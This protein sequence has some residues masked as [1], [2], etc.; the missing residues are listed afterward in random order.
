VK[1][2]PTTSTKEIEMTTQFKVDELVHPA[3]EFASLFPVAL[4]N[5]TLRVEKTPVGANGVNYTLMPVGGGRGIKAPG[6]MLEAGAAAGPK[7]YA[8]LVTEIESTPILFPGTVVKVKG[9]GDALYVITADT[10][11]GYRAF[12]LG[13]S[14]RYL[15]NMPASV[16]TVVKGHFVED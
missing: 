1:P 2:S 12:P 9:R 15:R 16:L 4:R 14:D 11:K 6:H 8:E 5:A 10:A 3:A 7:S 13:G